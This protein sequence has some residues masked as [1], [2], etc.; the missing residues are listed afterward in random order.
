MNRVAAGIAARGIR[1]VRFE[2]PYMAK[3]RSEGR[4]GAPDR[5]PVLRARWTQARGA[6]WRRH[7][8]RRRRQVDGRSDREHDRRRGRRAGPG[9]L[10][11]PLSPAGTAAEAP[12]EA[13]RRSADAGAHSPGHARHVRRAR[14][15]SRATDCRPRS[16]DWIEN[17]DHSFKPRARSGRTEARQRRERRSAPP[18]TSFWP[19]P[20]EG[21]MQPARMFPC[22]VPQAKEVTVRSKISDPAG[23]NFF[24]AVVTTGIY[25]RP[26]CAARPNPENVR[27]YRTR[28]AA[29]RAGFR[30][31]KRC[32]PDRRPARLRGA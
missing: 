20:A 5:E 10:R 31:C 18:R 21:W 15:K 25:C 8:R 19:T 6:L 12:D 14:R 11:V 32:K 30:P 4:R 29:E 16:G 17:G 9:V 24:Q 27:P 1:V 13:P 2:F 26:S 3:R 28:A 22:S 7:A 23:E